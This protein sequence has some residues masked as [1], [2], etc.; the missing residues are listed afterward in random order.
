ML[1]GL[2]IAG[3]SLA[4]KKAFGQVVEELYKAGKDKTQKAE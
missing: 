2:E 1:T 4:G 3:A